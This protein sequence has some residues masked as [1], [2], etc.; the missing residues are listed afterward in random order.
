MRIRKTTRK[1][2]AVPPTGSASANRPGSQLTANPDA[3]SGGY[4]SRMKGRRGTDGVEIQLVKISPSRRGNDGNRSTEK[5]HGEQEKSM[6]SI[7]D[8]MRDM[9]DMYY[10]GPREKVQLYTHKVVKVGRKAKEPSY[11][12]S[13]F[14]AEGE[15]DDKHGAAR[16]VIE[17]KGNEMLLE[18]HDDGARHD[19]QNSPRREVRFNT[20]DI[21]S[22]FGASNSKEDTAE[23]SGVDIKMSKGLRNGFRRTENI[24]QNMGHKLPFNNRNQQDSI[25]SSNKRS[26]FDPTAAALKIESSMN[27]DKLTQNLKHFLEKQKSAK[28]SRGTPIAL[29]NKTEAAQGTFIGRENPRMKCSRMCKR[30]YS[31]Q[32]YASSPS[33]RSSSKS[34]RGNSKEV[35]ANDRSKTV[36]SRLSASTEQPRGEKDAAYYRNLSSRAIK[37]KLALRDATTKVDKIRIKYNYSK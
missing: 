36:C 35:P 5:A 4:G 28:A 29:Q 27:R 33:N 32:T 21:K 6:L 15:P 23:Y 19:T 9:M 1:R 37:K 7:E 10:G 3:A 11:E 17:V 2:T 13:I 24:M 25:M 30:I 14:S 26:H 8:P 31:T 12:R 22:L 16:S 34:S 20:K 18:D